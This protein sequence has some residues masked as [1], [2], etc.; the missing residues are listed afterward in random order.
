MLQIWD[1]QFYR[2][3]PFQHNII[4]ENL[5]RTAKS[6]FFFFEE[7]HPSFYLIFYTIFL[8]VVNAAILSAINHKQDNK[9]ADF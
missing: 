8:V 5:E 1:S 4:L 2:R 6:F 7:D 3:D 9:A